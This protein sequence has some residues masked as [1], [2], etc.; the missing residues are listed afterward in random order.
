MKNWTG[1]IRAGQ[2]FDVSDVRTIAG[3]LLSGHASDEEKADFLQALH[4]RGETPSEIT[5]FA[6]AFL[7][8]AEPFVV[9]PGSGPLVDV[10]GT[11]GDKLGLF[12]ISTAVMFVAAGAGAKVVKHG[13]RGVTSRSGGADVLEALGVSVDLPPDRLHRMLDEAG[14]TFLF[15]PKFHPAFRAVA[16][17]R[18]ILAARGSA[19][20]FNML[21]PL[22]NPARPSH[23][24]T[25]V[26]TETLLAAYASVLSGLGRRRAWIVH[27][28]AGTG[29]VMDEIS[30]LGPTQIAK[31]SEGHTSMESCL[32][33][34]WGIGP[35]TLGELRG[36]E[37]AENAALIEDL[38]A[39]RRRDGARDIVLVN[40]AAA[41]IVAGIC[42]G[43]REAMERAAESIDSGA[44]AGVL[45]K[46]RR[47]AT[48]S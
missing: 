25:G 45:D 20:I 24:L 32:A 35:G 31:V 16:P 46:M 13:N 4:A 8:R 7:A 6:E 42:E 17:A 37:A 36:G 12:N 3:E 41:L 44:A 48:A 23:Q 5:A 38:F 27:G 10:C 34:D 33:A 47:A 1:E 15:A 39:G 9:P 30:T 22:L 26:F 43:P 11:G 18:K 21:G 28:K 29:G 14:A 2:A 19:S 40:S